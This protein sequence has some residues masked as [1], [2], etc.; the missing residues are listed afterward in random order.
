MI[1][2]M[3][4]IYP[5]G[6]V[7]QIN[8]EGQLATVNSIQIQSSRIVYEVCWWYDSA[9]HVEWIEEHEITTRST[10]KIRI[11]FHDPSN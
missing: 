5:P 9:R 11:G 7:I 6:T 1:L 10:D 2:A 3:I 8:K 4:N